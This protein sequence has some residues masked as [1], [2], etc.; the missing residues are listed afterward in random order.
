MSSGA[1]ARPS[2][3]R[4]DGQWSPPPDAGQYTWPGWAEGPNSHAREVRR[5]IGLAR[6]S[7]YVGIDIFLGCLGSVLVFVIRFGFPAAPGRPF[8]PVSELFAYARAVAY[9]AYLGLYA[10]LIVLACTSMRLYHTP[11]EISSWRE[12]LT[13]AR[14]V[15][16]ATAL[17]VVFIFVSGNRLI[18]R[19]VII[20]AGILNI[21]LLASWRHLKRQYILAR[22]LRGVGLSRALIIGAGNN[23]QVFADWLEQN[24]QL[25]FSVCGFLDTHKNGNPRV[26]GTVPD[27]RKV[28]LEKFVDHLFLPLPA[29]SGLVK[30]I[31][32]Q[33][34]QLR[35]NLTLIPELYDG[36]MWRAPVRSM[37]GVPVIELHG[38]PIPAVGLAVKRAMDVV[39]SLA[40]LALSAP[41]LALAAIWIRVDSPGSVIY[42]APRMGRKGKAFRCHKLRTMQMNADSVK[43][44]LREQNERDGPFFKMQNDPRITFAGHW[45][46]KYSID[47]LPQLV[48]VL[49]GE[50]S[51]V[52][53][54][55]HPL[56]DY[57]RYTIEHFRR[58]DVKPGITGLWQLSGD[59][60]F[61]IHENIEY[62]LYYIRHR[63]FFMDLAILLHTSIFAMRGI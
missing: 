56:D 39:L 19:Q 41:I 30:D 28:V 3:A 13:V 59:R 40:G 53:P 33:A 15:S 61:L 8:L 52:G 31:W 2:P 51:L 38:Q 4:S 54:R 7:A 11:R 25:G 49:L 27:L 18:S 32:V 1:A 26:L 43:E 10:A 6:Q 9:P 44:K 62:D 12:S 60:A 23:G 35:L 37:A 55:P 50:M 63:N 17:L 16:L 34:R 14:A 29:E 20:S 58:L 46:R 57:K 42:S 22:T 36:I 48:N 21:V 24:Q 5:R 47:E 45:L